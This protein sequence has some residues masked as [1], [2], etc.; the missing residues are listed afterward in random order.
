MHIVTVSTALKSSHK[1]L[2]PPSSIS[3]LFEGC[4]NFSELWLLDI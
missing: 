1:W 3:Q 4:D 2:G